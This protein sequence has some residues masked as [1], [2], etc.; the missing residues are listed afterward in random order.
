MVAPEPN[1]PSPESSIAA[2]WSQKGAEDSGLGEFGS[3]ATIPYLTPNLRIEYTL[4]ES[5]VPRAWWRSVEHSSSGFVVDSFIDELA[6][7]VGHDPLAFRMKLIGGD[8]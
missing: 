4:A 3:G 1:S 8:S 5:S 2:K 7:S 6:A